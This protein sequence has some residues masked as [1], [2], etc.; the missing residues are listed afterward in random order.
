MRTESKCLWCIIRER[1]PYQPLNIFSSS[2]PLSWSS[3][4]SLSC[5]FLSLFCSSHSL[6]CSSC[7]SPLDPPLR[8]SPVQSVEKILL[9][10][11]SMLAEPNDESAANVDASKM[12]REDRSK[13][14]SIANKTVQK[15][16]GL[17]WR[18][19]SQRLRWI[20][21]I[22]KFYAILQ[23][24]YVLWLMIHKLLVRKT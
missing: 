5:S 19:R 4:S 15:S 8:W 14:E 18:R 9:S 11:V 17:W 22:W 10:V 1:K 20:I 7:S 2:P 12:W 21:Y 16:L 24:N 23:N 3:H 6:F 13:F